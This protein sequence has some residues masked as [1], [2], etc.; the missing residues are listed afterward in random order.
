MLIASSLMT[1]KKVSIQCPLTD[2]EIN[3]W[4]AFPYNGILFNNK[5]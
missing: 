4:V 1:D 3:K 2:E 5:K